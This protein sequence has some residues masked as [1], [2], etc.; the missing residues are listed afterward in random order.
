MG[1]LLVGTIMDNTPALKAFHSFSPGR[2]RN[3]T[4]SHVAGCHEGM[5]RNIIEVDEAWRKRS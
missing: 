3:S 2:L 1:T 4:L 5:V